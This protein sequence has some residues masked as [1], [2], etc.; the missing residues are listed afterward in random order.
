MIEAIIKTTGAFI[1]R[2]S[3]TKILLENEKEVAVR[4]KDDETNKIEQFTIGELFDSHLKRGHY[5]LTG[6][7]ASDL[8]ED[9]FTSKFIKGKSLETR[10][11]SIEYK[12]V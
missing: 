3:I 9:W 8:F 2:P 1:D 6:G 11:I 4:R 7:L 12:R 5:S 10:I